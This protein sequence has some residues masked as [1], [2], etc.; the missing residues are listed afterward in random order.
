MICQVRMYCGMSVEINMLE[1]L[2]GAQRPWTHLFVFVSACVVSKNLN[3][4][5]WSSMADDAITLGGIGRSSGIFLLYLSV[6]VIDLSYC[7]NKQGCESF[8]F[9]LI[10]SFLKISCV[11]ISA[12]SFIFSLFWAFYP[13][14]MVFFLVFYMWP[15]T[16]LNESLV[17]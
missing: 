15:L 12:F 4:P 6:V 5:H 2:H 10:S 3:I 14:F 1:K 7:T 17:F 9:Q 11:K 16:P 8:S 13:D